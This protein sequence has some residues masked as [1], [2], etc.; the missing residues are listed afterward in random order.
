MS[1]ATRSSL[2]RAKHV[3]CRYLV[4]T[5]ITPNLEFGTRNHTT[6]SRA[7]TTGS[8]VRRW[9]WPRVPY[10]YVCCC[11]ACSGSSGEDVVHHLINNGGTFF[12][13]LS[14]LDSAGL[15]SSNYSNFEVGT[16]YL[17]T[18]RR[19]ACVFVQH[20]TKSSVFAQHDASQILSCFAP[21][22][23]LSS[24]LYVCTYVYLCLCLPFFCFFIICY[25]LLLF[26]S[27]RLPFCFLSAVSFLLPY[28]LRGTIVN[29][30]T[31]KYC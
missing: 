11:F 17:C 30:R 22:F 25:L 19:C 2:C 6:K 15:S 8:R 3:R 21:S 16:T 24:F 12:E 5:L 9:P 20:N 14:L 1:P 7:C 26:T 10:R 28:L 23:D 18:V 29:T 27:L 13:K 4:F 31:T